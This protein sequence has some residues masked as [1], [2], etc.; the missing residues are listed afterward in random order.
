MLNNSI[1][2][3]LTYFAVLAVNPQTLQTCSSFLMNPSNNV[4]KAYTVSTSTRT[5]TTTTTA[6][7]TLAIT[8]PKSNNALFS[9]SNPIE[10]ESEEEKE[11]RMKLVRQLQKSFYQDEIEEI[12][13]PQKGSTIIEDV[14]LLRTQ[15]SE[16]PGYQNV[17]HIHVPHYTNMFQKILRSGAK[18]KYFGHLYLPGGS[19]NLDNPEYKLEENTKAPLIGA[20]M[21]ITSH[22]ELEDGRLILI[23]QA[24]EKFRVVKAKRHYSPYSIATIEI[25]PD[26]GA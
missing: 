10:E 13:P 4:N 8:T 21:K 7:S 15:W 11:A 19:E 22:R 6:T 18:N 26:N 23:V 5:K 1:Q 17:L 12:K 9:S 20:L 16:L 25:M 14:P 2:I 24:L 3:L